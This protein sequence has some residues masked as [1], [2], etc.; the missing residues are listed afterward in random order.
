M[1]SLKIPAH[2][3]EY[4]ATASISSAVVAFA[5]EALPVVQFAAACV[6]IVSGLA[7]TAWVL[8][9]FHLA[10]KLKKQSLPKDED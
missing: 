7:A 10:L 9:K 3:A 5:A 1:L 2:A 4:G 6:A 8:Y